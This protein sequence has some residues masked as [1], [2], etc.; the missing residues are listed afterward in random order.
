MPADLFLQHPRSTTT[1]ASFT[2]SAD[3]NICPV[4]ILVNRADVQNKEVSEAQ[5]YYSWSDFPIPKETSKLVHCQ[6]EGTND[7]DFHRRGSLWC[8]VSCTLE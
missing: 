5:Q 3:W 6:G 1:V 8:I 7:T 2:S 4:L